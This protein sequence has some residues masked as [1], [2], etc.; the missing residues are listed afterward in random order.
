MEFTQAGVERAKRFQGMADKIGCLE[1]QSDFSCGL[2][3]LSLLPTAGSIRSSWLC[4]E[5]E[6]HKDFFASAQICVCVHAC[7]C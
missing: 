6:R 4:L 1:V 7:T 5:K 3:K 2:R